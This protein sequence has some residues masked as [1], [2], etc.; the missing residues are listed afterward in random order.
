MLASDLKIIQL[1]GNEK[2]WT[3]CL[4][5]IEAECSTDNLYKN[6][7]NL[8]IGNYDYFNAAIYKDEI[9]SF[10]GIE[11]SITKWGPR[12]V[13]VLSKFWI[14][15]NYRT[16]G[17]TKWRNDTIKWSPTILKPQ[18]DYLKTR[19]EIHAAIITR[20]GNYSHSFK[21]I[22][23]LANTVSENEFL[24]LPGKHNICESY[25]KEIPDSCKQFIAIASLNNSLTNTEIFNK[26]VNLGFFKS[27]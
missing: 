9:I 11:R 18:L 24:I 12:I 7:V 10:G 27:V 25:L 15:P 4:R 21:E 23:R 6:Y 8:D 22:V 20:E 14:N 19:N 16:K 5:Y 1:N 26:F 17:L 2:I 3:D 13:R